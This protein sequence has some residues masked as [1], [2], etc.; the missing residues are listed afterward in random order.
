MRAKDPE[1][2]KSY[3]NDFSKTYD[4][5]RSTGYHKLIDDLEFGIL[6]PRVAGQ[7]VLEVGCGTG[8]LLERVAPLAKSAVGV[9][10]SPGMLVHARTRG[11]TVHE[12]SA[13][14]LPFDDASFDL[15]YSFKVL[16]HV[17]DITVALS[18]MTRV[19]RPGGLIIAEFYNRNSLRFLAR[20]LS[21]RTG[22]RSI[23]DSHNEREV[24]TRWDT[25]AQCRA[26]FPPGVQ[27]ESTHGVRVATPAAFLHAVP[28]I[29]NVLGKIER[30]LVAPA[31]AWGGF[32]VVVART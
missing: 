6:Q 24:P 23:G 28:G 9:D 13:T 3:Y 2:F 32:Y 26:Y 11:L 14:A 12:G 8:L 19:V 25:P 16:A 21:E 30:A 5:P 1:F 10:L 18:E 31:A 15:A 22:G 7:R 29:A 20:K 17:A 4:Q 27:I